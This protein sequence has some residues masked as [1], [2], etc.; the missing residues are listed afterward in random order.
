MHSVKKFIWDET[1][2]YQSCVDGLIYRFVPKLE[3]LSGLKASHSSL[4]AGNHSG[5][6]II[7]KILQCG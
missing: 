7:H 4:V 1:Y 3:M 5:I 2:L 6:R